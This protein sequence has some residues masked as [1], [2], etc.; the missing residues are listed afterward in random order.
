MTDRELAA[1]PTA[2]RRIALSRWESE[3]GAE[4]PVSGTDHPPVPEMNNA[5]IVHLRVRVIALENLVIAVLADGS[6]RQLAVARKMASYI[7]PRP[8]FTPHPLTMQ[9]AHHITDLVDRAVHFR[10]LPPQ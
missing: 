5:E 3:G 2:L 9:G 4:A 6:E 8:G 1:D 7:A 10:T